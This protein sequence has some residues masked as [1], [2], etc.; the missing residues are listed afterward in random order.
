MKRNYDETETFEYM[1][2][3]KNE[4]DEEFIKRQR[5]TKLEETYRNPL[6]YSVGNELH[7]SSG[8][9]KVTIEYA[10]RLITEII[11]NNK[12][13]YKKYKEGDKKLEITYIVDSPGGCVSSILKFADFVKMVNIK[14]PYVEFISI[15]TGTAASA[16][17][18]M[19]TIAHK[20]LMT[21]HANAMIHELSS[22]MSGSYTKLA[23][24][25]NHLKQLHND[26]ADIYM[27]KCKVKRKRILKLLKNETWLNATEYLNL[28]LIDEII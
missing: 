21:S 27:K 12:N 22:G 8:I 23:S 5:L 16:G 26:L 10:I 4:P 1:Y 19:S 17:T 13:D 6:I 24:Y 9:N 20:R 25:G 28:G 14:H 3:Y 15:I 2:Q 11:H 18:I 7:F